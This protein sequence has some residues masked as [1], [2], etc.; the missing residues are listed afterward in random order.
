ME[1]QWPAT[2]YPGGK[3]IYIQTNNVDILL[4][5]ETHFTEKSYFQIPNYK[6]YHTMHPDGSAHGG[7]A[8][9]IRNNIKHHET[10]PYRTDE[11]QATN[12]RV[13]DWSGPFTVSAVYSPPKHKLK[14]ADYEKFL[15]T[16]GHRFIAGGDYNAKHLS[17]GSRI[18]TTKGRQL[19]MT[20]EKLKLN[21]IS[22][23]Q[24]TYWPT[25]KNKIPDVID[26]FIT[27][28]IPSNFISCKTSLEL[29]SDHSPVEMILKRSITL[30]PKPCKLHTRKTDWELFKQLIAQSLD[31]TL[32]LKTDDNITEA[33]EHFNYCVQQSA[34]AATPEVKG[35]K[36]EPVFPPLIREL[37]AEKRR[38]RKKWQQS[39]H[40]S[41]K[42]H[43]NYL[44]AKLKSLLNDKKNEDMQSYLKGLDATSATAYSLW[45]ATKN[46]KRPVPNQ[47]PLRRE[48]NEWAASDEEKAVT[49]AE[50]LKHV[51]VPNPELSPSKT[52]E[53]STLL[54]QC[55]QLEPPI[56]TF[57]KGEIKSTINA[58][59]SKKAPGYDL[60]TA[61]ILKELPDEGFSFLTLLYNAILR[62]CSI[63]PQWKVAQVIMVLKPGKNA[64]DA[65]SY[66]PISLL[67]IPSK[68][69]EI[70]FLRRLLPHISERNLLPDH[71]FGFRQRH[72]TIEQVH[73]LVEN[74]QNAFET[75]KYCS[76]SFLDISQAFD[77]VWHEG[78]L[79]K[80]KSNLPVNYYNFIRSYLE[81]RHFFVKQGA[82]TTSLYEIH[83]G[84]P[85]SSVMGP[86]L[87]L[88]Y[89]A[90]LPITEGVV[91]G[92]F[93]DDTAILA[94]DHRPDIA[95]QKLQRS[96]D[97]I[98]QWLKDWRI[99]VN[100]TKSIQ[101]TFTTKRE[102]CPPVNLNGV[103]LPQA[104]NAK[105]LGVY[106]DR[107]LTW[108][109]H[110]LTKRCAAGQKVRN[111][112][113]LLN[114]KSKLSLENKLLLYKCV[115]KP[116]WTYGLQLWGTAAKSNIEI[117]QRFQSKTLRL[118]ANA[119]W[120]VT[121]NRIHH[122]LNIKTVQ[123]EIIERTQTYR[124]RI[125]KHPNPLV[126]NLMNP[127]TAPRRLKR[128]LP[129]DL[130]L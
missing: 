124:D 101:V 85:Q 90:D 109:K 47:P 72:G 27:K 19:K 24:P 103:Q 97:Q 71:Q 79:F 51:F 80:I 59:N 53:V 119:P 130:I 104:D 58:F 44:Q 10:V 66:R 117:L 77:R 12:V 99:K 40:A 20:I 41:D 52:Q 18:I 106:L 1:C 29:S 17:W 57:S 100:E 60:I 102:T 23:G 83:A 89:T 98:Y 34:W 56:S 129:Q 39:R 63:P 9:I 6:T 61:K 22:S 46:L 118:L 55:N 123:E 121:N 13:E 64:V 2:T 127:L 21:V 125:A 75:N 3:I 33:V 16:L 11:I 48:N 88:L 84:V 105:Y 111:M 5:S 116:I 108:S 4:V 120:Y 93:A 107:R 81:K 114:D 42:K 95:S 8:V 38:A 7:S 35:A 62:R 25:D 112:Y 96:L 122:D 14:M 31:L 126:V 28:G 69:M 32:P 36:Y 43:L 15:N 92:T 49:F 91:T 128:K 115:I 86:M 45:K 26:F 82:E 30:A 76:S 65:K 50:H 87:Y 74:I 37:L 110:I 94:T 67:P 68:V 54:Q 78:L 70:L 113:W 73:R